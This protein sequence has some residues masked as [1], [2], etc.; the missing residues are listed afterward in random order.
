MSNLITN[1]FV[2]GIGFV[3]VAV[4]FFRSRRT[5]VAPARDSGELIRLEGAL[6]AFGEAKIQYNG[7]TCT[8]VNQTK[9]DLEPGRVVRVSRIENGKIF[10]Q[11]R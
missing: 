3:L 10:V 5:G 8:L 4:L 7:A 2:W 11:P 9:L 1:P 6:S